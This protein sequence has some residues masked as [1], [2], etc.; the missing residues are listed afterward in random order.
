[1]RLDDIKPEIRVRIGTLLGTDGMLIVPKFLEAR[2][3]GAIGKIKGSA[4]GHKGDVWWVEHE[5]T[6]G[7]FAA[8][9]FDEFE[10]FDGPVVAPRGPEP[11]GSKA[12]SIFD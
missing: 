2:R 10:P 8:Y 7:E 6:P 11:G 1:M 4:P 5:D 12:P 9:M 3:E